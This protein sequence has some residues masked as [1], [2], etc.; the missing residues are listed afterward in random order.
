MRPTVGGPSVCESEATAGTKPAVLRFS[1]RDYECDLQGIVNNAAYLNYLEHA[2]H[3]FL[4]SRGLNF[5]E[6][7]ARGI[8]LV[9]AKLELEYKRPL[10]PGDAF[11]VHTT[12]ARPSKVRFV[13]YQ[14]ILCGEALVLTAK[15]TGTAINKQG[16]P[17]RALELDVLG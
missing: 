11:D 13:F 14:R 15:V 7:S 10:R 5:S 3:E 9:V 6:L 17:I 2:R 4:K 12:T 8:D 16:R 1:V